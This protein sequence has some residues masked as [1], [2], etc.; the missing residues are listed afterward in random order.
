MNL[1][2]AFKD[3]HH[4]YILFSVLSVS[5]LLGYTLYTNHIWEDFFITFRCSQNLIEGKGLVYNEGEK[6]HVFTSPL[7][8]L[9]P[10]I[11]YYISGKISYLYAIWIFRLL[12]CIPAF[13][14]AVYYFLK[15]F[16]LNY[17]NSEF[18]P[19]VFLGTLI[20][21]DAKSVMFSVNGMETAFMLLFWAL[22][23]YSMINDFKINSWITGITWAGFMWTRPD[24][25][26]YI[27][28]II[29]VA[30]IFSENRQK[31]M[32]RLIKPLLIGTI[33]YLPWFLFAWIYYGTP[34]P[35]TVLA[36]KAMSSFSFISSIK[37][38]LQHISWAFEAPYQ[39]MGGWTDYSKYFAY[40]LT[41]F[42][43]FY[44]L[45]P[46]KDK[47]GKK[48]SFLFFLLSF[49]FIFM[50]FPYPWYFPPLTIL[51]FMVIVNGIWKIL[52]NF[53]KYTIWRIPILSMIL[54]NILFFMLLIAYEMKM[55]Q[56]FIENGVRK[57]VG[58]WLKKYAPK[59]E[60]VYL[61]CLGYI[62]FFSEKKM[63]DYPGLATPSSVKY[64][65]E[66]KCGRIELIK[67]LKPDWV[68]LR[69]WE[70]QMAKKYKFFINNYS[71]KK[72]ISAEV[73][74]SNHPGIPG[75]SYLY[76][77]HAFVICRKIKN[78]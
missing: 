5:V 25:C 26:V 59:E 44:W 22:S 63:L 57:K 7:G 17:K 39:F 77:D 16:D 3:K 45:I 70:F 1:K 23:L 36:K 43:L 54:F 56:K 8:V 13:M 30:F 51:G 50:P 53:P 37:H 24:S 72:Y 34:V 21:F 9:L 75:I 29:A 11:S 32:K 19:A 67:Y 20:L 48:L 27:G 14:L 68:V 10:A 69:D 55:Q 42:S 40:F 4:I 46:I 12:F 60:N 41:L 2:R 52:E 73:E 47:F 62:G 61:E 66:K 58:L 31:L 15:S 78:F 64:L 38:S 33:F 76:Y 18:L 74:L 6:I 49:Y 35:N 71:V 28:A 65:K